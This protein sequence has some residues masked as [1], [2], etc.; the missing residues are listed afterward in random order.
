MSA[1][2][3]PTGS[4]NRPTT[5]AGNHRDDRYQTRCSSFLIIALLQSKANGASLCQLTSRHPASRLHWQTQ[6]VLSP[7]LCS[8]SNKSLPRKIIF[9]MESPIAR[10][11]LPSRAGGGEWEE[12]NVMILFN[13]RFSRLPLAGRSAQA[14][15]SFFDS[16]RSKYFFQNAFANGF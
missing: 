9:K 1:W 14:R 7:I 8:G 13:T 10:Q 11:V 3:S 6:H 16:Y 12:K 4:C 15:T 2:K 5:F